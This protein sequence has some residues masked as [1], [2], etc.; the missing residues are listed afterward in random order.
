MSERPKKPRGP[1]GWLRAS[2]WR[3]WAVTAIVVPMLYVA[4][5]GPWF[6]LDTSGLLPRTLVWAN[7]IYDPLR[8]GLAR[9]PACVGDLLGA[10]VELWTPARPMEYHGP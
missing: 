8:W 6:W 10:Y 7:H 4:S 1:V 3:F 9:S 2:T 5:V